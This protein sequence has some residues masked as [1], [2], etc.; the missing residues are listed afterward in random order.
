MTLAITTSESASATTFTVSNLN[1]M[2]AGSLRQATISANSDGSPPSTV[3]FLDGL[4]GTITLT[5]GPIGITKPITIQGPGSDIIA[6]S[7]NNA[8]NIFSVSTVFSTVKA[9][10]ISGLTLEDGHANGRGGAIYAYGSLIVNNTVINNSY[11]SSAGGGI[12]VEGGPGP[13]YYATLNSVTLQSNSAKKG[14]GF[15]LAFVSDVTITGVSSQTNT[16]SVNGGGGSVYLDDNVS[17]AQISNS[18]ITGNTGGGLVLA[19][20]AQTISGTLIANNDAGIANGGGIYV[21]PSS[22]VYQ[23]SITDSTISGNKAHVGGGVSA[24][25]SAITLIHAQVVNNSAQSAGG[26]LLGLGS[27]AN[28][29]LIQ[30]STIS[31]NQSGDRGGGIG[32]ALDL[33]ADVHISNSTFAGNSATI[34]GGA[35]YTYT[36]SGSGQLTLESVTVAGNSA[37]RSG[38]IYAS[39]PINAVLHD[40][41]IANNTATTD[42]DITGFFSAN[43]NLIRTPG[44]ASL[45]GAH[46]IFATDPMLGS[47]GDYGG[48]T[49]TFLP[50]PGSPALNAGDPAYT[51]STPPI[52]DQRAL[53]RVVGG[54]ID[55]GST[56]RQS[57]EDTI[58]LDRFAG[59]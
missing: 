35:L 27:A 30:D 29:V 13:G 10:T 48:E 21:S 41:I 39:S 22:G 17:S 24:Y 25:N 32:F 47:F 42:A 44:S 28:S 50:K 36:G 5:S 20:G 52:V 58:F 2:G 1:D 54:T 53:T 26:L 59:Y 40:C 38:G 34:I 49:Q 51:S 9:A 16:C 55:L 23:L 15:Y 4:S 43:Y 18:T 8:S 56:E 11:S 31:A 33:K 7:G 46:N 45:S 57:N 19:R 37:G 6:V 3:Q 12:A 14:C